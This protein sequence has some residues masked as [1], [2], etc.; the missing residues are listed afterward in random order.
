MLTKKSDECEVNHRK[1]FQ[2]GAGRGG[3][4]GNDW[5]AYSAPLKPPVVSLKFP[6]R[7]TNPGFDTRLWL[8]GSY[9][10]GSVHKFFSELAR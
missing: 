5:R 7:K 3:G 10:I 4:G 8:E 6:S 9:K 1:V 2:M